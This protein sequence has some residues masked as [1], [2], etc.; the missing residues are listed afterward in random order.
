[1]TSAVMRHCISAVLSVM[2]LAAALWLH[3]SAHNP[4][5][6]LAC[7]AIGAFVPAILRG[8]GLW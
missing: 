3:F 2:L 4:T 1:M 8:Y 7:A 6:A 5:A